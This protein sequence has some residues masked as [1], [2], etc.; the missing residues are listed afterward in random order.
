MATDYIRDRAGKVIKSNK[1][2]GTWALYEYDLKGNIIRQEY[3]DGTWETFEYNKNG[4]LVEARNQDNCVKLLRD[5]AGRVIEEI[6]SSGLPGDKGQQVSSTYDDKGFR[7]Q[8]KSSPG[9][10]IRNT[11]DD[12][13]N[14]LT[15]TADIEAEETNTQWKAQITRNGLGQEMEKQLNGRIKLTTAYDKQGRI[16]SHQVYQGS[17]ETYNRQYNWSPGHQLKSILNGLTKGKTEFTYDSFGS[18]ASACYQDGSYDYKLPDE[19][20]NLY[21]DPHQS[22]TV[23]GASGKIL[24]DK[25]WNYIY[26]PSGNLILKTS[27]KVAL[28]PTSAHTRLK[29]SPF[30]LDSPTTQKGFWIE[31]LDD[32]E[33]DRKAEIRRYSKSELKQYDQIRKNRTLENADP[34]QWQSGDW[35]YQWQ[36]NGMLKAVRNPQGEWIR[37]EYDALGRRTAKIVHTKIY[38]YLWDGNVLLHEWHYERARRPKVITDELGMLILDQPEPVEN[39]T[40]WVYEEGSLVPTAKLCEG[41]S[42]SIVSDYLGRPAQAYDDKGELVWQVDFDI[43][44]RIREDTLNNK[45]FI[46]FRQLGQYED[47]ETGLYYNRFRYYDSNTGTYISQDPIG[48]AGNNPNFYAYTFDSNTMVDVFGLSECGMDKMPDPYKGVK[49]ASNMMK[50]LGLPRNI[51]KQ[52]LQ[53][54]ESENIIIRKATANEFGLRYHDNG[55]NAWPKGRYLFETFPATRSELAVKMDWNEMTYI[56]QFKIKEG[57]TIFEGRASSQ[58]LGLPGGKVQKYILDSPD[59]ALFDIN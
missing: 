44:G 10:Y 24:K 25:K 21:S 13:G 32:N 52:V 14:L 34:P 22:D 2:G 20:G 41:K 16:I 8:L 19:V 35:E 39:L 28:P 26:D 57:T 51:R 40:T 50:E 23:Y 15:L 46:P 43:Y 49:E 27:R 3:S 55:K 6:Q 31:D 17:K 42:Y 12:Q 4:Q 38:R 30:A 18:L 54:F 7:T 58:G 5:P 45:P 29:N 36:G 53:S 56:S 1:S 47:V 9:A 37:F 48:L 59:T 33:F 11:F